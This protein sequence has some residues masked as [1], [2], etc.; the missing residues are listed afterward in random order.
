MSVKG[1][2]TVV[3]IF[4]RRRIYLTA[5]FCPTFVAFE[6]RIKTRLN[7]SYLP[8]LA[9]QSRVLETNK[10]L[11]GTVSRPVTVMSKILV[12]LTVRSLTIPLP[13]KTYSACIKKVQGNH[14]LGNHHLGNG[15]TFPLY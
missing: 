3:E 11:K 7:Q 5:T 12:C 14:H 2:S 6:P 9:H 10:S 15:S 1:G 8:T 13:I 4:N